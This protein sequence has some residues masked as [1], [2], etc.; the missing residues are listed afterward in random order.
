MGNECRDISRKEHPIVFK[1]LGDL[2]KMSGMLKQAMEVKQNIEAY[3]EKLGEERIE[4]SAGGGMVTVVM[5]GTMEVI[6]MTIDPEVI[7]REESEMLET[8]IRAAMNEAI[9][10]AKEMVHSK[11]SELTGGLDVP[12]LT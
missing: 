4:A 9:V 3:K 5:S 11:M 6:S 1:G 7:D 10:K 2:G 8:L 12:G